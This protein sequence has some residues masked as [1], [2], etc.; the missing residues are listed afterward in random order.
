MRTALLIAAL[1]LTSLWL[2]NDAVGVVNDRVIESILIE[3]QFVGPR[4]KAEE[5]D[6]IPFR[7]IATQKI[8]AT[9][10]AV[11]SRDGLLFTVKLKAEAK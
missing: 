8:N 9:T 3:P 11:Y 10:I 2:P 7:D 4:P 6:P 5:K 1:L